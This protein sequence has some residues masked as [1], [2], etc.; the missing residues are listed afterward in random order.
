MR[1]IEHDIFYVLSK[2]KENDLILH[3]AKLMESAKCVL[4]IKT[5]LKV[6]KRDNTR[7]KDWRKLALLVEQFKNKTESMDLG[8]HDLIYKGEPIRRRFRLYVLKAVLDT[9]ETILKILPKTIAF[10]R[11]NRRATQ[12]E[13]AEISP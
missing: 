1:M 2:R 3:I 9:V 6:M 13:K 12:E 10:Y 8:L 4:A 11:V 5:R 7:D